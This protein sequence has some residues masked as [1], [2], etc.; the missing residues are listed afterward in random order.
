M[1]YLFM[2]QNKVLIGLLLVTVTF[3][4]FWQVRHHGFI[5]LDDPV[6]VRDNAPVQ[7][8]LSKKSVS[9]ALR[10]YHAGLWIPLTWLSIMVD[11]QLYGLDPGGYHLTNVILHLFNTLLLFLLLTRMTGLLWRSA[12]VAALFALHPLHVESVAWVTERKD[13][14]STVFWLL[15]IW[16]YLRYV[17]RPTFVRYLLALLAFA[18]GLMAKPMVVTLPCVLLLLDY[19]PLNRLAVNLPGTSL[20]SQNHAVSGPGP[21]KSSVLTL[22]R[23]K[24]PFFVL[25][26][27]VGVVTVLAQASAGAV[28]SVELFPFKARLANAAVSYLSY[29]GK[30]FWPRNLAVFYPHPLTG[31]SMSKAAAAGLLLVVVSIAVVRKARG[32]PYLAVGWLWYLGTLVPVIGLLQVGSQ[33]L[34]DRFTYVPLIGLFIMIGWGVPHLVP[35][36]RYRSFVLRAA[37]ATVVLSLALCTHLQLHH[38]KNSQTIFTHAL[39]VTQNNYLAHNNLGTLLVEQGKFEEAA[40]HFRRGVEI[41]PDYARA[42][43]NLALVMLRRG[44]PDEAATKFRRALAVRPDYPEAHNQLG[45]ALFQQ[46]KLDASVHAYSKA[47]RYRPNYAEAYNNLGLALAEQGK[48]EEAIAS[49]HRA[50]SIRWDY[51]EAH[52]H[53]AVN[54]ART[55]RLKEAMA[56]CCEALRLRPSWAQ[57]HGNLGN[58]L[59]AQGKFEEAIASFYQA[60]RLDP[61]AGKTHHNLALALAKQGRFEEAVG[62][63]RQAVQLEPNPAQSHN[64]LGV[65][66]VRLGRFQEAMAHYLRALKLEPTHAEAHNNVGN[67]LARFGRLDTAI[68]HYARALEIRPDDAKT[69]NNV[70]AA[71]ARQKD[72]TQA[73]AHFSEALRLQP[74]YHQ[75]RAN[76][77]LALKEA[78]MN[79][80]ELTAGGRPKRTYSRGSAAETGL[81]PSED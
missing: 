37:G 70:G 71:L 18:L 26:S 54:L 81:Q 72:F 57:S 69:H 24:I 61:D 5:E 22:I 7:C 52:N 51:A 50:L 64:N 45:S 43:Y 49:Y 6:Y 8:A 42:W 12:L 28:K 79:S 35:S 29:I 46:G 11:F 73:V 76:L 47:A 2:K 13:V 32:H 74:D 23:E 75:A 78:G 1:P 33:G 30:M 17:E 67:L 15:T 53:L 31:I 34:A 66:L 56:H 20:D 9:W 58:I 59:A 19:W 40:L 16:A 77:E 63:Y 21:H 39:E 80:G 44:R 62:H 27:A 25:S 14:L 36:W 10:T 38:W 48:T 3:A 60:L 41:K 65:V 55:G 4:V 68:A